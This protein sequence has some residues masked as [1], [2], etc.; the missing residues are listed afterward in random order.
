MPLFRLKAK[1]QVPSPFCYYTGVCPL[2]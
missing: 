1:T 2:Y